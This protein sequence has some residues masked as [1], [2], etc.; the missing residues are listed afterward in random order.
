MIAWSVHHGVCT[1]VVHWYLHAT[2]VVQS[3]IQ[4]IPRENAK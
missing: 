4:C 2:G 3:Y 1:C